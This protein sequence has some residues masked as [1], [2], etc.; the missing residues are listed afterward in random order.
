[1]TRHST[2]T[3]ERWKPDPCYLQLWKSGAAVQGDMKLRTWGVGTE[4]W[5]WMG[6]LTHSKQGGV[7]YFGGP[8]AFGP[9]NNYTDSRMWSLFLVVWC[10]V[11]SCLASGPRMCGGIG[12]LK[13]YWPSEWEVTRLEVSKLLTKGNWESLATTSIWIRA[14]IVKYCFKIDALGTIISLTSIFQGS[15]R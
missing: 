10:L 9:L 15:L 4:G 3:L 2:G 13:D 14:V 1:M 7:S 5:R 12:C 8:L 11:P 6:Q